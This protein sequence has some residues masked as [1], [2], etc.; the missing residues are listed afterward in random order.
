MDK[1]IPLKQL[2]KK[3]TRY[4][5]KVQSGRPPYSLSTM[6]GVHGMHLLQ[7]LSDPAM[8]DALYEIESMRQFAGRNR[9][10]LPDEIAI[11]EFG[12]FLE[13]R[14]ALTRYCS[15]Q[16]TGPRTETT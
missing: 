8:D 7:N 13:Q 14:M 1:L 6:L 11:L 2:E 5:P 3:V 15:K 12:H 9:D 10:R 16:W 4:Y